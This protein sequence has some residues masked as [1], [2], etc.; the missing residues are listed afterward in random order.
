MI[1]RLIFPHAP[2][3]SRDTNL[4]HKDPMN[5]GVDGTNLGP[6]PMFVDVTIMVEFIYLIRQAADISVFTESIFTGNS[7]LVKEPI[8]I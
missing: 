1:N 2:H 3:F 4:A 7:D 8:S 5:Q 6:Q